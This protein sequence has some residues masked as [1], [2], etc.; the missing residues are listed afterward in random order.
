MPYIRTDYTLLN[1]CDIYSAAGDLWEVL[2]L[3]PAS[4]GVFFR[5][6]VTKVTLNF[7][8]EADIKTTCSITAVLQKS[9]N[10]F[11]ANWFNQ[12]VR[13]WNKH[14]DCSGT[15]YAR[16]F[17]GDFIINSNSVTYDATSSEVS[18]SCSDL[19]ACLMSNYAG[20]L[21]ADSNGCILKAGIN[22]EDFLRDLLHRFSPIPFSDYYITLP[23][24]I[25]TLPYDLEFEASMSIWDIVVKIRDLLPCLDAHIVCAESGGTVTRTFVF[26]D[27]NYDWE[28]AERIY[29]DHI[30]RCIGKWSANTNYDGIINAVDLYGKNAT[31]WATVK[32][33]YPTSPYNTNNFRE[34]KKIV[35]NDLL[36]TIRECHDMAEYEI[37]KCMASKNTVSVEFVNASKIHGSMVSLLNIQENIIN[38]AAIELTDYTGE[39]NKYLINQLSYSDCV[40]SVTASPFTP[41][42]YNDYRHNPLP[43]P[44]VVYSVTG[45]TITINCSY[46][47][48]SGVIYYEDE[49]GTVHSEAV[50]KFYLDQDRIFIGERVGEFTYTLP[51]D[52]DHVVRIQAYSPDRAP[53]EY[54]I[55]HTS[56]GS[57][58][59]L[60]VDENNNTLVDEGDNNM[61]G[62]MME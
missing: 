9:N 26:T 38:N 39:T 15:E 14:W 7:D 49:D 43:E 8:R 5:L 46:G 16:A 47:D 25:R 58:N 17:I 30:H 40:F 51:D 21:S 57:I 54:Y 59:E 23:R 33:E 6:D 3:D 27:M 18:F 52:N 36:T 41:A 44:T 12:G 2:V 34:C 11:E 48:G 61:I 37:W 50:F 4:G 62:R 31:V 32:N 10:F 29:A 13:I 42:Y 35:S 55:V 53:S 28:T 19:T 60:L 20:T 45:R 1:G 22:T 56:G 24:T